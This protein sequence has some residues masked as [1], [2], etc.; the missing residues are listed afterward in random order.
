M[1]ADLYGVSKSSMECSM[2]CAQIS[3]ECNRM[4]MECNKVLY[5]VSKYP[6]E[7]HDHESFT[8]P[9]CLRN[10]SEHAPDPPFSQPEHPPFFLVISVMCSSVLGFV[11]GLW[12]GVRS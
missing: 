12:A 6:M 2:E 7:C 1:H 4:S 11:L 5:G 8:Q 9:I 3:M 10:I